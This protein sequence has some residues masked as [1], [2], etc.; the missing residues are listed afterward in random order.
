[1][2]I[3]EAAPLDVRNKPQEPPD[4]PRPAPR[5]RRR[6]HFALRE[7]ISRFHLRVARAVVARPLEDALPL[8]K[9]LRDPAQ[10]IERL[11]LPIAAREALDRVPHGRHYIRTQVIRGAPDA[12]RSWPGEALHRRTAGLA[13]ERPERRV[14]DPSSVEEQL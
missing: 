3:K 9:V 1:M 2:I 10:F 7:D 12:L 5:G 13:H 8:K 11:D 6:G 4:L 14:A